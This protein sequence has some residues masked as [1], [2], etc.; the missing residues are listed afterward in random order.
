MS[1]NVWANAGTA[2]EAVRMIEIA[3]MNL[4]I[5]VFLFCLLD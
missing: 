4:R 1:P 3:A 5:T 2:P